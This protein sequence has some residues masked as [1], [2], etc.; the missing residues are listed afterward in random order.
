MLM[1]LSI[2]DSGRTT[3]KMG[4][5]CCVGVTGNVTKGNGWQTRSTGKVKCILMTAVT[6]RVSLIQ[7]RFMEQVATCG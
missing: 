5:G 1:V 7:T 2:K 3:R 6:T 4:T